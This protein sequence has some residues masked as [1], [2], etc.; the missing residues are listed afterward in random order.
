MAEHEVGTAEGARWRALSDLLPNADARVSETRQKINL[1]AFGFGSSSGG[2]S[3]PGV[4]DI[5]GP[6]NVFDAR[7]YL[8]Q[9][10]F[11][12]HALNNQRA[13]RNHS[14]AAARYT[15]QSARDFVVLVASRLYLQALAASARAESAQA[16]EA[17]AQA[18]YRQAVDLKQGGLIAGI[19]VL[20][21]EVELNTET[22]RSTVASNDAEKA[23]LQLARAIGLPL[24]QNFTLDPNLPDLPA[25]D[26]TLE[27]AVEAPG[28]APTTGPR[29]SASARPRPPSGRSSAR[30]CPP[31]AS[32]PTTA[33]SGC[34]RGTRCPPT[35]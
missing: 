19:D 31:F 14:A 3:F 8:S 33:R 35:R 2:P 15:Y 27:Q 29:S 20:R 5:V 30:R 16:Q 24:G 28:A 4:S 12:L 34:P 18:L 6:F 21:A 26:L 32:T 13:E 17:S 1:A 10:V 22:Q 11:D 7:V 23:K 9:A 25:P